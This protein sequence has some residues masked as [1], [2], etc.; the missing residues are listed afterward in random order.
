MVLIFLFISTLSRLISRRFLRSSL[1]SSVSAG[2][3]LF[4]AEWTAPIIMMGL[5][6]TSQVRIKSSFLDAFKEI[7]NRAGAF[8]HQVTRHYLDIYAQLGLDHIPVHDS[9]AIV[10]LLRP[11]LFEFASVRVEVE[12]RGEF[13]RGMTVADWMGK[14]KRKKQTSVG[15]NVLDL[16]GYKAFY[17]SMIAALP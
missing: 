14:L 9:S 5:D 17:R 10:A 15:M 3:I 8:I 2:S 13:T 7:G 16:E 1:S 12:L 6:V 4:G 11:D